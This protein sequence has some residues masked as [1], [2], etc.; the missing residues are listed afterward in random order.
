MKLFAIY[1]GGNVR[2]SNLEQHNIVFTL[3]SSIQEVTKS[4]SSLWHN[5]DGT[6]LHIDAYMEV[7]CVDGYEVEINLDDDT[8]SDKIKESKLFFV[9]IGGSKPG[10]LFEYHKS[11]FIVA[12]SEDE[13]KIR[14]KLDFAG[15]LNN[16]HV[17]NIYDIE[18]DFGIQTIVLTPNI[19]QPV[20]IPVVYYQKI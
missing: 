17:D 14:A 5:F 2:G 13:A 3:G 18:S 6:G 12:L 10:E 8:W 11:G 1:L 20:S 15:D 9:N 19:N 16:V 4:C 7:D